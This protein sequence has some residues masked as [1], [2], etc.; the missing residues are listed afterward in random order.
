MTTRSV[1]LAALLLLG[2]CGGSSLTAT[3]TA[4]APTPVPDVFA[5]AR[6][7]LETLGYRQ[8]SIDVDVHRVTARRVDETVRRP[9]TRFR[10]SIDQL[11]IEVAPQPT[12]ETGLTIQAKTLG[13]YIAQVGFILQQEEASDGV[14]AAARAMLQACAK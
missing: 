12:G 1:P 6:S 11:E 14:Q 9:D 13:E 8:S 4:A 3:L 5:C 7:Q 10:R 2:A